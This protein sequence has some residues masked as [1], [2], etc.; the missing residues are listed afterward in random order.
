MTE[1]NPKPKKYQSLIPTLNL[2]KI[3]AVNFSE[4]DEAKSI[5][6]TRSPK[7]G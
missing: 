3:E 5:K 2:E 6:D 1:E 7:Y 4:D